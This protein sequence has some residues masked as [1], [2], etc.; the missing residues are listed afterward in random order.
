M[1]D[2]TEALA[3]SFQVSDVPNSTA[4]SHP[5]FSQYKMK[6]KVP[7][8]TERRKKLLELQKQKRY[9]YV[10]HAR[11]LA[12]NDWSL[13]QRDDGLV[14]M[15]A[16]HRLDN[17][18]MEWMVQYCKPPRFYKDQLMLSEWLV[19]VPDDLDTE[20]KLVLCPEGKRCLI[21]AAKGKTIAY[22]KSGCRINTF[23]SALPGGN[24]QQHSNFRVYSILDCIFDIKIQ[25]YYVLDVLCWN[26][27]PVLDS[28]T[29]FRFYW[30][31]TKMEEISELGQRSKT[32][33]YCFLP[34]PNYS[35]NRTDV[36]QTM[37]SPLPFGSPLD[38]LLFYHKQSHYLHG[39]TPLVG[40]LKAYMLPEVLGVS[41]PEHYAKQAPS[42][43][44]CVS[45][46]LK[47]A[48]DKVKQRK[49][50][51]DYEEGKVD[52]EHPSNAEG[53]MTL[54]QN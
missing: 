43:Y 24:R 51:M 32:N 11:R 16:S 44:T 41:I 37:A 46:H 39:V 45:D 54:V 50:Q 31:H 38:G 6:S 33:Q 20:W 42:N 36:T 25:T 22:T 23:P 53:E 13:D 2:V 21:V 27:L 48:I 1:E 47:V 40:W 14:L 49:C 5:R 9:D 12:E 3:A 19:E 34:L 4:T 15:D 17:E 7:C 26:G 52:D 30:L 10:N 8:Q 29:E 35:C 28:E 18:E